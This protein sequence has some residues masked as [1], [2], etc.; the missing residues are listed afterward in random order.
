M[1][2]LLL[3]LLCCI[4]ARP[5]TAQLGFQISDGRKKIEIPIEIYN[6]L[7]VVPVIINNALPLKFIVDTGVRTA[8]LTDKVYTDFLN[9]SYNRKYT[10]AGA[11]EYKLVEA[12]VTNGVDISIPG[13]TGKGHSLLVLEEDYLKL[14]NYLGTSVHG[15]LGY[16]LFSRFVV[17]IDYERKIM[18]VMLPEKLR[19]NKRYQVLPIK[20]ED[21]KPYLETE[22]KQENGTKKKVKLM[23]DS[24]ASHGIMLDPQSDPEIL[25]P[26]SA[27]SCVVGHGLGGDIRGK[28]GRLSYLKFGN[29]LLEKIIVNYPDKNSYMDTLK[30]SSAFRNG[31]LGG[32]LLSRFTVVYN[33]S[34][35]TIAI[36]KNASFKKGFYYNLSGLTISAQGPRLNKFIITDVRKKSA[37][38][39]A[40]L[41]IGDEIIEINSLPATEIKLEEINGMLN[42]KAGKKINLGIKRGS[43]IMKV[44]IILEKSA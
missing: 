20:I 9:L 32:D 44:K 30:A 38:A 26:D 11:G 4:L 19:L 36:K 5:A 7:V 14:P 35:E 41:L 43:E 21:T 16:E 6:N 10:I 24:G 12:Y 23:V 18:T 28:S 17:K 22:I 29:Y 3:L 39:R 37:S 40:G 27:I 25:V 15:I 8:I 13:L 34:N 2:Y 42:K 33:F 31:T 1:R